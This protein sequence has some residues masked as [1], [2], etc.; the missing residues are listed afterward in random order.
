MHGLEV[1]NMFL[2]VCLFS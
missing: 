2:K 1:I